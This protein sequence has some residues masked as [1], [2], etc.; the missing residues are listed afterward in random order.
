MFYSTL[1]QQVGIIIVVRMDMIAIYNTFVA[2]L[3]SPT[4]D[5][6]SLLATL[7]NLPVNF[8]DKVTHPML[9]KIKSNVISEIN[10]LKRLLLAQLAIARAEFKDSILLLTQCRM[11]FD[12]WRDD[13]KKIQAEQ[14]IPQVR[15]FPTGI[16]QWLALFLS[17][18]S[19]KMT[20]YFYPVFKKAEQ[21][22][23][24][25]SLSTKDLKIDPDYFAVVESFVTRTNAHNISLIFECRGKPYCKDGYTCDKSDDP[26]TGINSW[27]AIFSYPKESP[28]R[29]HWPNIISIILDNQAA[30]VQCKEP[31][32][33]FFDARLNFTYFLSHVEPQ[34]TMA[35]LFN[36]KKK[37]N[38]QAIWEFVSAMLR[39]LRN[40]DIFGLLLMMKEARER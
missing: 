12:A 32:V 26:P 24:G 25:N 20:L 34:I 13:I 4:V 27:P 19:A 40:R 5:Y 39:A 18:L 3:S 11:E 35:I 16:H 14:K 29:E 2:F 36:E 17:S 37:P 10:V 38:E 1:L 9:Y 30:L 28:P 8:R 33:Y 7:D 23:S 22:V 6:D 21:E 15:Q 31:F